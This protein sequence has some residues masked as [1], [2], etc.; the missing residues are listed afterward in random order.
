MGSEKFKKKCET[1]FLRRFDFWVVL[2]RRDIQVKLFLHKL[3]NEPT[4]KTDKEDDQ[5]PYDCQ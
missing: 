1:L 5:S 2:V 4:Q 3:Q